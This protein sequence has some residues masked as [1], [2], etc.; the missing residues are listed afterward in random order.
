RARAAQAERLAA[1]T[2]VCAG[3]AHELGTPLGTIAIA[4]AE[5]PRGVDAPDGRARLL[6][7]AQLIGA[8]VA[9]CRT[10]LDRMAARFGEAVGEAPENLSASVLFAETQALLSGGEQ[11]R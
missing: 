8:E 11:A 1:L 3:A 5:L 9:R 6:E 7:D 4:A 10:I 2:T